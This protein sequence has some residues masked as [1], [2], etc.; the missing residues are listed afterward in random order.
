MADFELAWIGAT[1]LL[2]C[3]SVAKKLVSLFKTWATPERI[4]YPRVDFPQLPVAR[5]FLI[6]SVI[7]L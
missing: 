5:E 1:T 7:A 4:T 3:E 2:K 6:G